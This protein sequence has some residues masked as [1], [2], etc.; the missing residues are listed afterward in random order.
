MRTYAALYTPDINA[1]MSCYFFS[2][3][4]E[5]DYVL[6]IKIET[7]LKHSSPNAVQATHLSHKFDNLFEVRYN[8][9]HFTAVIIAL[10]LSL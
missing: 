8:T 6:F 1:I 4:Y 7:D 3:R 5:R 2:Q 9:P 10:Q